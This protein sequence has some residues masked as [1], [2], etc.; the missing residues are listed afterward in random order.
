M[1]PYF[2]SL[3]SRCLYVLLLGLAL[4]SCS[5][6]VTQAGGLEIVIAAAGLEPGLDF[7]TVEG[8]KEASI[9]ATGAAI[10]VGEK[11]TVTL[12]HRDSMKQ[13]RIALADLPAYLLAKIS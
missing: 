13:E 3:P 11:E 6:K 12:R 9:S 1:G 2:P 5:G 10:A 8:T 4:F 7:D